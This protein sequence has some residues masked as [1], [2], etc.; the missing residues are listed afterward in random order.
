MSEFLSPGTLVGRYRLERLLGQGGMGQV[1]AATDSKTLGVR[2]LKFLNDPVHSRPDRRRRFRRE[3]RLAKAVDYPN[4][5]QIHDFFE[6]ENGTPVMV[7]DLLEGETFGTKL[8]REGALPLRDV[9]DILLPVISAVGTAHSIG[10]IHRDLK[11]D[12]V[13]LLG[14]WGASTGVCVLDFG[15]AKLRLTNESNDGDGLTDTG[16]L[17]GTPS[18][19]SPEQGFGEKNVDHR[20]DLWSVGVMLYEGV[21]GTRPIEG[22]NP[23]QILRRLMSDAIT[24]LEQIVPELPS[25]VASLVGRLLARDTASRPEDLR[26][27]AQ[28][29][30]QIR[31]RLHPGVRCRCRRA[32]PAARFEPHERPEFSLRRRARAGPSGLRGEDDRRRAADLYRRNRFTRFFGGLGALRSWNHG[33]AGRDDRGRALRGRRCHGVRPALVVPTRQAA[34]RIARAGSTGAQRRA[35][36]AGRRGPLRDDDAAFGAG[37]DGHGGPGP[38]THS[39]QRRFDRTAQIEPQRVRRFGFDAPSRAGYEAE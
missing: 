14:P 13:F 11:P 23:R 33:R 21:S 9:A 35:V 34:S 24:P 25:E 8:R 27:V 6:L 37:S 20:T 31:I 22:D 19:T 10:I 3:A 32:C 29:F 17:L 39:E 26:E 30:E 16:A 38:D 4:V 12:N 18:Y 28:I 5:V 15:I 1:W 7:M 36:A 2:A